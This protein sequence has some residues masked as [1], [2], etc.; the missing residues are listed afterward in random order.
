[1]PLAFKLKD[2]AD[3]DINCTFYSKELEP[4]TYRIEKILR[5]KRNRDGN[6]LYFVK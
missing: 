6:L 3:E 2:Q 4:Q 5:R 1:M